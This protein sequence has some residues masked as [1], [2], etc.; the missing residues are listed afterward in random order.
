MDEERGKTLSPL[1]SNL[2]PSVRPRLI[3]AGAFTLIAVL[4]AWDLLSDRGSGVDT[5]HLVIESLVLIIAAGSGLFLLLR[6][7]QQRRRL[8]ELASQIRQARSD[9]ARWRS[10]YQ[11]MIEGLGQAIQTQFVEWQLSAAE[12]EVALL[13]LK[14][15]QLGEIAALRETSERTVR[16]QARA[17]YRKS[18][19]ANRAS[20]SAYFLEDLLLP[21]DSESGGD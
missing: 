16:D 15:L 8:R 5:L 13:I 6:D 11:D 21:I 3:L 4:V 12:S 7:W 10:R 1:M 9:S 17:V 2:Q 18:G 14:G 19:L 20:L